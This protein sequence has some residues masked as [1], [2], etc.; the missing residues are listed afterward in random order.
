VLKTLVTTELIS[1]ISEAHG[2]TIYGDLPVGFKWIAEAID[3][4]GPDQFVFA[5]EESHGYLAGTYA[6]DK[7]A[8][9]AALVLAE[10]AA[11]VKATG[12]SLLQD[13]DELYS[14]HGYH[15]ERTVSRTLPGREGAALTARIMEA[16]RTRPPERM[17]GI[18]VL[19]A[20]DYVNGEVRRPTDGQVIG[21]VAGPSQQQVM[22]EFDQPGW[23]LVARPSGTEPK[24]KFY[25]F[26]VVPP[27]RIES[28][29]DL[30]NAKR[31]AAAKLDQL[32]SDLEAY[33]S[34]AVSY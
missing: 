14:R 34:R 1:R 33:V 11:E 8:A 26:G 5:A 17:A 3:R 6:R 28:A 10:L 7:D 27:D 22:L 12:K 19:R 13:L 25:L 15:V 20:S 21:R 23:R 29:A 24:I 18:S 30:A 32:A 9:V 16:F 2:L 31:E 4:L